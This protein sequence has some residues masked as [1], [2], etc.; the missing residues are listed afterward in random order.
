MWY[1]AGIDPAAGGVGRT[2]TGK[3]RTASDDF[4]IATMR[5]MPEGTAELVNLERYSGLTDDQMSAVIHQKHQKFNYDLLLMDPNG[6]GLFVRDKLRNPMQDTG[7]EKFRVTP[8]ITRD[9]EQM[10]GVGDDR[11]VLFGRSDSRIVGKPND[12]MCPGV[13]LIFNAESMLPNK[14]HELFRG[15]LES[16]PQRI[17]FPARWPG[18]SKVNFSD[19]NEMRDYLNEQGNLKPRDRASAEIDLALAQLI[20]VDRKMNPDMTTPY[21]DK[22]GF[23]EFVSSQKKDSAYAV[24]YAFF[25]LWILRQEHEFF[26]RNITPN[27][28][29]YLSS[30]EV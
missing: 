10:A 12:P 18:W 1:V 25:A 14:M 5:G 21:Q 3:D 26:N 8:L 28:G 29:I 13:G 9:D 2:K 16:S 19:A 23:Y 15:V 17:A 20:Q 4:A 6:G 11:L 27:E 24:V 7:R 22:F 30:D